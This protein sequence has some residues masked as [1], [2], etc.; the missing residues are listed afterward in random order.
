MRRRALLAALA[1]F[2]GCGSQT[3]PG[4]DTTPSPTRT[5]GTPATATPAAGTPTPTATD[6]PSPTD[7]PNG[8]CL[9]GGETRYD[10]GE[11]HEVSF[12]RVA[13]TGVQL[14]TTP[15]LDDGTTEELP[16]DE[17]LALATVAVENRTEEGTVW[18]VGNNWGFVAASCDLYE[19]QSD[20][21]EERRIN[22][23]SVKRLRQVDHQ[24]QS[25][26]DGFRLAAGERGTVWYATVLPRDVTLG[27]L[28][29]GFRWDYEPFRVR[30]VPG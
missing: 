20:V 26:P 16:D 29:V 10:L 21:Y 12:W 8:P 18:S 4:A 28:E 11:F 17:Q 3:G 19:P 7:T 27:D 6:H 25:T 24:K 23:L 30:W 14:L 15:E 22:E 5:A 1:A 9:G 2:A 13:V